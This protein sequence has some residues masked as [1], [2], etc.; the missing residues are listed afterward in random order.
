V[1]SVRRTAILALVAVVACSELGD[2]GQPVAIEFFVPVPTVV[3]VD[4]TFQL[5]AR[6]LDQNGDSIDAHVRWRTP[7]TTVAVDSITGAFSGL[8]AGTGRVQPTAGSLVG[9]LTSFTVRARADTVILTAAAE[10]LFVGIADSGRSAPLSP[11]VARSDGTG[12][13]DRKVSFRLILP[14][15]SS[16]VLTG[17]VLVDTLTTKGDGTPSTAIRLLKH[18]ST[19]PDSAIVEVGSW[20]PSGAIVA[21]SGQRIRIFFE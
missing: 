9:P 16:V 18:G 2:P 4:D 5:R 3:E 1:R 7:D 10:S 8:F 20:R 13:A 14:T 6:V 19:L 21:G 12:L 17:D 11:T 15:D